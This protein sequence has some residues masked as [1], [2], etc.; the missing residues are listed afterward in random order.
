[1]R[2]PAALIFPL[3]LSALLCCVVCVWSFLKPVFCKAGK[4]CEARGPTF[5]TP[6]LQYEQYIPK[7]DDAGPSMKKFAID[8][9][10][11]FAIV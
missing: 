9:R 5:S 2:P 7:K 4:T 3:A 6:L 8:R 10:Q 11:L 1:M